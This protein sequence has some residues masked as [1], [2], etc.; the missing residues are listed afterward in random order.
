MGMYTEL[1]IACQLKE[2]TP[3][4]IIHDLK[5]L[6]NIHSTNEF[7]SFPLVDSRYILRCCSAYF[8]G[9]PISHLSFDNMGYWEFVN[10]SNLKNYTQ[11]IQ[12][13][14][15][16]LLP[17]IKNRS[18]HIGHIRHEEND[19]PTYLYINKDGELLFINPPEWEE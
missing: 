1:Y 7:K 6:Q 4:T 2:D 3:D 5:I 10:L 17:Y 11:Q 8:P 13:F 9:A 16:W 19:L 18:K 15:A 14:L 12:K